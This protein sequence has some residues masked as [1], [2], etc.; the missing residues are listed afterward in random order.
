MFKAVQITSRGVF[1]GIVFL[2][3]IIHGW[4]DGVFIQA[5]P[6]KIGT[7]LLMEPQHGHFRVERKQAKDASSKDGSVG[8]GGFFWMSDQVRRF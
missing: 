7:E 3:F 4:Y 8:G 2:P 1:H 6:G 5:G